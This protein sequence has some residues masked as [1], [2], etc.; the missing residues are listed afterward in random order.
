MKGMG[1]PIPGTVPGTYDVVMNM[2]KSGKNS[3]TNIQGWAEKGKLVK[4]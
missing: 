1:F 3:G 2:N 4:V